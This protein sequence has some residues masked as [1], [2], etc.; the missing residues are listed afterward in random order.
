VKIQRLLSTWQESASDPRTAESYRVRLPVYDAARLAALAELFPGRDAEQLLV[1]LLSAALDE[2]EE[3]FPYER[4]ERVVAHD[5]QGDP[6]FEDA[7]LGP[8][9][10]TLTRRHADRLKAAQ[11]AG[12]AGAGDTGAGDA[13]AADAE[14]GG[15]A[16]S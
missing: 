1:E 7:G 9:F 16:S 14:A 3:A 12:D 5:E 15:S 13:G 4:G 8:R 2:L 11:G 6:I 10:H